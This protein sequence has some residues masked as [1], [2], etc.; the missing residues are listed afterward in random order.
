MYFSLQLA[1]IS[2]NF[3][4]DFPQRLVRFQEE[5]AL[6]WAELSR[7]LDT[8][9]EN[10]EALARQGSAAQ[11]AAHDGAGVPSELPG[12]RPPVHRV[13]EAAHRCGAATPRALKR[14]KGRTHGCSIGG[15]VPSQYAWDCIVPLRP[16]Y[17]GDV[18]GR[19]Q[20]I[21]RPT[22]ERARYGP[23]PMK[24]DETANQLTNWHDEDFDE[25]T[26]QRLDE[27]DPWEMPS[28]DDEFASVISAE[29][30]TAAAEEAVPIRA[31]PAGLDFVDAVEVDDS[32]LTDWDEDGLD[33]VVPH[34]L[35]PSAEWAVLL[36]WDSTQLGGIENVGHDVLD[37]VEGD[38]AFLDEPVPWANYDSGLGTSLYETEE[39]LA[40]LPSEIKVG[41]WVAS[42]RE[43]NDAQRQ[44]ITDLLL[45][46]SKTVS[47]EFTA[48]AA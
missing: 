21:Q 35:V 13:G 27:V 6:P 47:P 22:F 16:P 7:R 28:A 14:K 40:N 39:D 24:H 41:E 8:H 1:T 12:P 44:E 30:L 38:D 48:L 23:W 32:D 5:S 36:E 3:P 20:S 25:P 2:Y 19:V 4:D 34:G 42:I 9:L 37:D 31:N 33:D 45:G 18:E 15:V 11:H 26:S 10:R 43:A 46:F 17:V 29:S